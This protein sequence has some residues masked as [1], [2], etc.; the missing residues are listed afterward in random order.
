MFTGERSWRARCSP[1]GEPDMKCLAIVERQDVQWP[2]KADRHHEAL[3]SVRWGRI[4]AL[5][6]LS[7]PPAGAMPNSSARRIEAI[8]LPPRIDLLDQCPPTA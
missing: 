6:E 1:I 4:R 5:V 8:Y 3:F 2:A 7:R